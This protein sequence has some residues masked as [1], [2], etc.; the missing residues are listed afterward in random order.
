MMRSNHTKCYCLFGILNLW[1]ERLFSKCYI[2]CMIS[3]NFNS[4]CGSP[5]FKWL[6]P[7]KVFYCPVLLIRCKK[8]KSLKWST[9]TWEDQM[10]MLVI[11]PDNYGTNT[12]WADWSWS[13]ETKAPGLLP[14]SF[15]VD[16]DFLPF[17]LRYL[18]LD[19]PNMHD[20]HRFTSSFKSRNIDGRTPSFASLNMDL[21]WRWDNF[22][23][24]DLNSCCK[25][26][27]TS[28]NVIF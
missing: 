25:G 24:Q 13:T 4:K 8:I 6:F 21:G 12:S 23:C 5:Y 7:V 19:V 28:G 20:A 1:S 3:I 27:N 22:S 26:D 9:M 10:C 15:P 17:F 18:L 16:P 14:V 2:V 11:F